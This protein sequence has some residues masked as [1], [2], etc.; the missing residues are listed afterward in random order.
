MSLSHH[1]ELLLQRHLDGE[2][3][4]AAAA[5]LRERL[6]AEPALARAEA[7]ARALRELRRS[8]PSAERRPSAGFTAGLLHAVR[9]LPSRQLLEQADLVAS[10]VAWCR[11]ILLAAAV[12]AGLGLVWQSGLVQREAA[13]VMQA[14]PADVQQVIE[15][16]DAELRAGRVPSKVAEPRKIR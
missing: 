14:D 1:D 15:R 5:T 12:I 16:L 11:R 2:L 13:G 4:A 3:D 10:G 6:A 7:G 9:Q 8:S